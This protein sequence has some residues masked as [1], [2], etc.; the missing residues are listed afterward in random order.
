MEHLESV[1][2]KTFVPAKDYE[3][4]KRF[5]QD[6]GFS[7]NSDG[8]DLAYFCHNNCSFLLQNF[9]VKEYADNFMMHML[10]KDVDEWWEHVKNT[11][12]IEKYNVKASKPEIRP[13]NMKDF[14]LV[15]PSS[16]LWRFGE[17]I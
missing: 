9:Y 13:W 7:M 2:I 3:L 12:V 4:S 11:G 1:E 14:I 15:D 16:V 17:N 5:Y 8:D 10:V 6:L